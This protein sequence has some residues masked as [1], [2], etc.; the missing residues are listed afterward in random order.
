MKK[1]K[2]CSL[3]AGV[4]F[5]PRPTKLKLT[6]N[7]S[8]RTSPQITTKEQEPEQDE[9]TQDAKGAKKGEGSKD[10]DK[11]KRQEFKSRKPADPNS[12]KGRRA[13][14]QVR[15]YPVWPDV[16]AFQVVSTMSCVHG[17]GLVSLPFK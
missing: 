5:T 13:A 3:L 17:E 15:L 1:C 6:Q 4:D 12:R 9:S 14:K 16:P 8:A 7:T 10:S 2:I 11:S